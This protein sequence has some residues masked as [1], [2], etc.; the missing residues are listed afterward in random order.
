M[1]TTILEKVTV[2]SIF[3]C[4]LVYGE[5]E[6]TEPEEQAGI[7]WINEQEGNAVAATG[8]NNAHVLFQYGESSEFAVCDITGERGDC[9]E[10]EIIAIHA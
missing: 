8:D 10:V 3:P 6:L 2:L 9:V 7:N 1:Q 4:W 5:G